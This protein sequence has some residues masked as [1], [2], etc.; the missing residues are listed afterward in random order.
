MDKQKVLTYNNY[1]R[2]EDK[3]KSEGWKI[4][5]IRQDDKLIILEKK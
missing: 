2:Q 3:L 1:D 5:E 4:K